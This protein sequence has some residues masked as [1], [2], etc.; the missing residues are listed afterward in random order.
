MKTFKSYIKCVA[1]AQ[2]ASTLRHG[3][4]TAKEHRQMQVSHDLFN[5]NSDKKLVQDPPENTSDETRAEIIEL[6]DR[7]ELVNDKE[8]KFVKW[9]RDIP[10]P[11]IEYLEENNLSYDK[12]MFAKII[13]QSI[14]IILKQK[15]IFCRPRPAVVAPLIDMKLTPVGSKT[16]QSPAYPSGHAAQGRLLGLYLASVHPEHS[17]RFLEMARE[18]GESRLDAGVHYPSDYSSG[19]NLANKLFKSMKRVNDV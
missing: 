15:Y 18:C 4:P 11:F 19:V 7:V 1:E 12:D 17:E 5:V 10:K 6:Q 3:E 8:E 2:N 9:D 13:E 14:A 16:T